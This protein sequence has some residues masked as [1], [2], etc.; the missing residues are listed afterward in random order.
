MKGVL[1]QELPVAGRNLTGVG[2]IVEQIASK[3]P[4]SIRGTKVVLRH[5]CDHS[6]AEG[7][8]FIA[9][10]NS[11]QLLSKDLKAA[12]KAVIQKR[13]ADFKD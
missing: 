2:K 13:R 11:E 6:L 10:W 8:D 3:S 9:R 5:S 7:L 1:I 4:L 12:I